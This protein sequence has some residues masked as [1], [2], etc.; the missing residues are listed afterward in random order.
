MIDSI[1]EGH[2]FV[3]HYRRNN[4]LHLDLDILSLAQKKSILKSVLIGLADL[5][6]HHILH[7]GDLSFVL[8]PDAIGLQLY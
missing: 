2:F 4:L 3:Y 7:S 1:S 5:H 6:D 8:I